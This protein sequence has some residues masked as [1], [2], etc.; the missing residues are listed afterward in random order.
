MSIPTVIGQGT[1]GCVLK[2]SLKCKDETGITYDNKVSKFLK[3]SDAKKEIAEYGKVSRADKKNQ[4][5]LGKPDSCDID[6]LKATNLMA[7]QK[8]KGGS[9]AI[10]QLDKYKLI[11]MEDGG[12]NLET[13]TNKIRLWSRSEMSTELCEKF[14]LESLRL[15]AG[16]KVYNDKGLI[17]YD[18]K[19]QNI[20]YNEKTNRM[21]FI[22][23]GL[24]KSKK[25]IKSQAQKSA[26]PWVFFHWSYPWE[27]E[28][29]NR[30]IFNYVSN[31]PSIQDKYLSNITDK[32][33]SKANHINNFFY[34]GIDRHAPEPEY[35]STCNDFFS[36]YDLTL[37]TDMH[38]MGYDAFL[39]KSLSTIDIYGVGLA[40]NYWLYSARRHIEP[41][42]VYNLANIFRFMICPHLKYRFSVNEALDD[43]ESVIRKSGLLEKYDKEIVD[44]IV[45]NSSSAHKHRVVNPVRVPRLKKPDRI[46]VDAEPLPCPEGTELNPKTGRCIKT[47][48]QKDID[49]PCPDGKERNPKTGRCIKIKTVKNNISAG[50]SCP[51]GKE[52]NPKTRRCVN[53][54]KPGYERDTNFRCTRKKRE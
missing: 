16:L 31:S 51:T 1:Y 53:V 4:F 15:F 10:Y 39:D 37:K 43:M 44:H 35:Q 17:H 11:L 8:C 42:L 18:L 3:V 27:L 40:M 13:Y 33:S 29:I 9:E 49:G 50:E 2:P 26:C 14:L 21:N 5:Y 38:E 45:V 36:G 25:T 24:M 32:N 12:E 48:K 54:C 28:L 22:D 20:V 19:P 52:R 34:Y 6:N 23:F 46:L 47:R 30:H 7:I 41:A